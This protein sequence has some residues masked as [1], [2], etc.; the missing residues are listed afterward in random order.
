MRLMT[1]ICMLFVIAM[2]ISR[3]RNPETWKGILGGTGH[4]ER[5]GAETADQKRGSAASASH[6]DAGNAAAELPADSGKKPADDSTKPGAKQTEPAAASRAAASAAEP[7]KPAAAK[8]PQATGPTDE[9][10]AEADGA[11]EDFDFI[12]DRATTLFPEERDA[13]ARI[14]RWVINQPFER[15]AARAAPKNPAWGEFITNPKE[16]RQP[17]RVFNFIVHV[18]MVLKCDE[19]LEIKNEDDPH[20]PV[21][22]YELWGTTDEMPSRFSHFIVYDPPAGFPLGKEVR[23]D[24]RFIGYFFRVQGYEPAGAGLKSPLQLAPSFIGRIA[25]KPRAPGGI[26]SAAELPWLYILVGGA[27]LILA[28]WLGYLLLNGRSRNVAYVATDLPPPPELTIENW[29]D[30]VENGQPP[31]DDSNGHA[32]PEDLEYGAPHQNGHSNGHGES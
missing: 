27:A 4:Q 17:G 5:V 10:E 2:L 24:A 29:L 18:K 23:E 31:D 15:L 14:T 3:A 20:D 12:L 9:D 1:M 19:K 6:A 16:F 7:A 28:L 25:W 21:T 22:M 11:F 30:R 8:I 26:V 32:A 13:W